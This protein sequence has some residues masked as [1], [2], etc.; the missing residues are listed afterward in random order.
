MRAVSMEASA[1]SP[2]LGRHQPSSE[3]EQ[4]LRMRIAELE[5][6]LAMGR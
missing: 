4:Q 5:Q 3:R 2:A 1:P 6:Q